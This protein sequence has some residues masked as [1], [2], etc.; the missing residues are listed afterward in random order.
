MLTLNGMG[1]YEKFQCYPERLKGKRRCLRHD[2]SLFS[3]DICFFDKIKDR[4]LSLREAYHRKV[5]PSFKARVLQVQCLALKGGDFFSATVKALDPLLSF[6]RNSTLAGEKELPSFQYCASLGSKTRVLSVLSFPCLLIGIVNSIRRIVLSC[7]RGDVQTAVD[8]GFLLLKNVGNLSASVAALIAGL[9]IFRVFP[10]TIAWTVVK[11]HFYYI[12]TLS[13]FASLGIH[14]KQ[15][16]DTSHL[17]KRMFRELENKDELSHFHTVVEEVNALSRHSLEKRVGVLNGNK[18]KKRIT[19][20]YQRNSDP[21]THPEHKRNINRTM[22]ELDRKLSL[23]KLSHLLKILAASVA[24][25]ASAIFLFT[26]LTPL[27]FTCMA[28]SS[29]I[30]IALLGLD[31]FSEKRLNRFLKSVASDDNADMSIMCA[32]V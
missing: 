31:Y 4:F 6:F 17:K 10:A 23:T 32:Q 16:I 12:G 11:T 20:I 25:A 8:N 13:S 5:T 18:L 7:F 2:C 22:A 9:Q 19:E 27:G 26:S 1:V 28:A 3:N 24:L 21:L 14:I 15:W 29:A 30:G